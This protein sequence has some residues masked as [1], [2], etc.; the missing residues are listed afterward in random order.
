M[1][2]AGAA[3]AN[4]ACRQGHLRVQQDLRRALGLID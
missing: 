4:E 1:A 2:E 3:C